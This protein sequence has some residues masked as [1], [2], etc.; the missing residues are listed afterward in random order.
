MTLGRETSHEV[1]GGPTGQNMGGFE[2][3]I[4]WPPFTCHDKYMEKAVGIAAYW[5]AWKQE[6]PHHSKKSSVIYDRAAAR[7]ALL[8]QGWKPDPRC[9][10]HTG[11]FKAPNVAA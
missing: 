1:L 8:R 4:Q 5:P 10:K 3:L 2:Y 9:P 6:N 7:M 11:R